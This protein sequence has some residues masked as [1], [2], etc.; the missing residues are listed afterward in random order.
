[1]P[2]RK[3]HQTTKVIFEEKEK[4]NKIL[5]L[6]AENGTSSQEILSEAEDAVTDQFTM[7]EDF[8]IDKENKKLNSNEQWIES[9][10]D[11]NKNNILPPIRVK[12]LMNLAREILTNNT[13][14]LDEELKNHAKGACEQIRNFYSNKNDHASKITLQVLETIESKLN[15]EPRQR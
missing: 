3:K 14:I 6:S 11:I 1:M 13:L 5:S 9:Y 15:N 12:K 7:E 4:K 8:N 10:K 2:K